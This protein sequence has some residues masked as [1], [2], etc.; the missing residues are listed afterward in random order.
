[1]N[2]S[3]EIKSYICDDVTFCPDSNCTM[4]ACYRNQANIRDRTIP[5]SYYVEVP[6]DC[7]KKKLDDMGM[8]CANCP[9]QPIRPTYR[10]NKV[11]CGQ[12]GKRIPLKIKA[13]FCH[14]CGKAIWWAP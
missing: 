10:D 1:M 8:P 7:M 12:C 11:Y 3:D 4:T 14:K 5:H 6:E 9:L 2:F 13:D